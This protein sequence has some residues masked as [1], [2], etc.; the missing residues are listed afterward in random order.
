M[1]KPKYGYAHQQVR[2]AWRTVVADG[3]AYC[4]EPVCLMTSRWIPPEWAPT[5][6]WH[7]CHDPT[8]TE[9][10]GV[11]HRRCNTSEGAKRGNRMRSQRPAAPNRWAL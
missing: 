11:G 3:E 10:I 1:A 4:A 9:V 8:G 6:L 5:Q 2:E 7:V